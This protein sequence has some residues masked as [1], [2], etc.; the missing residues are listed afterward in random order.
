MTMGPVQLVVVGFDEPEFSGEILAELQR[1]RE[2]DIVRV[3]DALAIYKDDAGDVATLQFSDLTVEESTELGATVGALIG[4]GLDGE[5]GAEAGAIIGAA[6]GADGHLLDEDQFVDVIEQIPN[7]TAAAIVMLEHRWAVPL[8]EII[9]NTGGTPILDTWVHPLDLI[10]V[11]L[12]AEAEAE[13]PT[14]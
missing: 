8:R 5:E 2:A 1:L 12:M 3:I 7:G 10:A 14:E 9:A 11:G 13:A 6:A 4:I